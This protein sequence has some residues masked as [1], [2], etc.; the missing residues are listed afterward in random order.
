MPLEEDRDTATGNM[1][2][3]FGEFWPC[4]F[5]VMPADR[6]TEKQTDML[7]YYFARLPEAK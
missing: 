3:K 6:Q 5:R 4:G 1:Q 7:S 2:R